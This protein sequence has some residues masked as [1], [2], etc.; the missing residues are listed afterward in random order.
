M[1]QEMMKQILG[2]DG[3]IEVEQEFEDENLDFYIP[4]RLSMVGNDDCKS[5][6]IRIMSDLPS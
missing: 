2:S 5:G 3:A 1:N 4:H 6:K